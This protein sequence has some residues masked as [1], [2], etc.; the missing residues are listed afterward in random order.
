MKDSWPHTFSHWTKANI[1]LGLCR[2]NGKEN[3]NYYLGPFR[4]WGLGLR[5]P[6]TDM[7][8]Q[9]SEPVKTA[10]LVNGVIFIES[11]FNLGG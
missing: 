5:I 4:V 8:L 2:D 9:N 10:A 3:G 6:S 1:I 11:Y 7:E